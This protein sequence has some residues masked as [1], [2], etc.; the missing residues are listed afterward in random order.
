[1]FD[2]S[3]K[4]ESEARELQETAEQ[5]GATPIRDCDRGAV[6]KACGVLK[7]VTIRPRA[8]VP[9]VHAELYDGSG[10]LHLVWLGRRRIEGITAGRSITVSGR[11]AC[12][13]DE[14]LLFNPKYQLRPQ[15]AA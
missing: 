1:M 2:V 9:A 8:G 10:V 11:L 15:G 14:K 4:G 12:E 7:S 3:S 13:N 6:V 5:S